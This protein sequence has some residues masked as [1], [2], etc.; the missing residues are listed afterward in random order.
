M[1]VSMIALLAGGK[2][3]SGMLCMMDVSRFW[4]LQFIPFV[5]SRF[6]D[7]EFLCQV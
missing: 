4:I 3:Y 7:E 2:S 1:D 6:Q 5:D